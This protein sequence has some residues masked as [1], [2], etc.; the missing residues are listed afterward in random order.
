MSAVTVIGLG[1]M[2]AALAGAFVKGGDRVTVWNRSPAKADRLVRAGATFGSSVAE[3]VRASSITVVCVSDYAATRSILASEAVDSALRGRTIVQLSTGTPKEARALES[4]M[5]AR[6][7]QYL[8]G[9][10]L[11]WPRQIGAADTTIVASGRESLYRQHESHLKTLA[12]NLTFMGEDAGTSAALFAAM[13]SYLA[14]H[15]IGLCQGARVC[16]AEGISVTAFGS[17]L[18]DLTPS[19]GV[20]AKHLSAVIE[21]DDYANPESTIKTTGEDVA[22]LVQHS[23][24]AGI[25]GEFPTFAA[26]LFR[27]AIDAGYGA[28]E[29]AALIKVLRKP[30]ALRV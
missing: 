26:G 23:R 29:H 19:L 25:N 27:R 21:N 30:P 4:W 22:R 8:D 7:A 11:A 13:L 24:E 14:G 2:G 18:A 9:A 12:G 15:W 6:R 1:E 17:M 3:A 28:E 10:I 5:H 20:E 16:E